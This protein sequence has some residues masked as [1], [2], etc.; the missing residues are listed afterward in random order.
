MGKPGVVNFAALVVVVYSL[1]CLIIGPPLAHS[2]YWFALSLVL[3][4]GVLVGSETAR[5]LVLWVCGLNVAFVFLLFLVGPK[6]GVPVVG[7][8][9]GWRASWAALTVVSSFLALWFLSGPQ[10]MAYFHP[11]K[12][13]H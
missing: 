1:A 8:D 13:H 9:S 7:A 4:L 6:L 5:V 3:G 12:A 10:A 2:S 11:Q